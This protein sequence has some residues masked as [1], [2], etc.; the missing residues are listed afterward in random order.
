[1]IVR[2]TTTESTS[3]SFSFQDVVKALLMRLGDS[4]DLRAIVEGADEIE[5]VVNEGSFTTDPAH[6]LHV[7]V[8]PDGG[9]SVDGRGIMA[10][11][12]RLTVSTVKTEGRGNG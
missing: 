9:I 12:A 7:R 6:E 1:M 4:D 2:S 11:A 8:A 5:V 10:V 3:V